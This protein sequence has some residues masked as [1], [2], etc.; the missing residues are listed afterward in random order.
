MLQISEIG[1]LEQISG[2]EVVLQSNSTQHNAHIHSQIQISAC[3]PA[4]YYINTSFCNDQSLLRNYKNTIG[5]RKGVI[6]VSLSAKF[7]IIV[8]KEGREGKMG[9]G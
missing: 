5:M 6:R 7:R 4:K 1:I 3:S 9:L 8:A 2:R